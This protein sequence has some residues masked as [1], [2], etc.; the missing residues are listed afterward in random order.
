MPPPRAQRTLEPDTRSPSATRTAEFADGI[1]QAEALITEIGVVAN[2]FPCDA[3]RL[4][5]LFIT[6]AGLDRLAPFTGCRPA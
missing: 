5:L 4:K 3:P 6:N 1:A 2:K